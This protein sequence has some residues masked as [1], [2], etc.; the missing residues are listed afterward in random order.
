MIG[1][2]CVAKFLVMKN[3]QVC[4][5]FHLSFVTCN[6]QRGNCLMLHDMLLLKQ[7]TK[8]SIRIYD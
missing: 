3:T 7:W 1:A 4:M 8:G 6:A 5:I 2:K